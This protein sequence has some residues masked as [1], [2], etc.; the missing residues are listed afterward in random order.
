MVTTNINTDN[1]NE[2][3]IFITSDVNS[4]SDSPIVTNNSNNDKHNKS[5]YNK[6]HK[7]RS[8]KKEIKYLK[9]NENKLF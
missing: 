6:N 5:N 9:G 8:R 2:I 3:M 1:K 4:Y 7:R